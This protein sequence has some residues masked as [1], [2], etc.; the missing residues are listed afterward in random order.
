M[1]QYRALL[2]GCGARATEHAD[3]Y[4][5][6][7]NMQLAACCDLLP[8]RVRLFQEKYGIPQGFVDLREAIET[9]KPDLVH[10]VTHPG[11]R[12]WEA[13]TAAKAGVKVAI[14]EKPMM[15]MPSDL[16][17]LQAVHDKYGMEMIVNCQRRYFPQFRDGVIRD[18]VRNRIGDLQFVRASTQGNSMS[19]GPHMMDLLLFFLGEA[20]PE[21]VWAMGYEIWDP[22]PG[23]PDYRDTHKSP[24]HLLSEY[25]FPGGTRVMF[26]CSRD[27]LGTPGEVNFWMHLHFDFLGSKGRL[28]LTQNKGYWYQGEGMAE[29]VRGES[30]W[31]TQG[32]QGQRD[33]TAAVA[34]WLDTGKPHLNRWEVAKAGFSALI[35]AQQSIYEGK[36]I[37]FP[38]TFTDDQWLELRQRLRKIGPVV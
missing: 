20:Q 17:K 6:I 35:G 11:N 14:I 18:I 37:N 2:V 28:Y 9:V 16:T 4:H 22:K 5:D 3:V 25:W 30:S 34:D 24:E 26:D 32:W 38:Q 15:V 19:M 23:Q 8:E 1:A 27:S 31:D 33:F 12:G 36:R 7:P 10:F 29:P 13:E 21:S